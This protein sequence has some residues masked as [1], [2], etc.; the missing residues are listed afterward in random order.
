MHMDLIGTG[1]RAPMPTDGP[2]VCNQMTGGFDQTLPNAWLMP[3]LPAITVAPVVRW[4][5]T[6]S[7]P[8][9]PSWSLAPQTRPPISA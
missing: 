3:T 1:E 9:S 7:L 2:C 5:P 8:T 6:S 4:V